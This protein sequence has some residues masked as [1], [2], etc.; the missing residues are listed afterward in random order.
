M[1]SPID[2]LRFVHTAIQ[3][4]SAALVSLAADA[5]ALPAMQGRL[6]DLADLIRAHTAGEEAGLFPALAER[7][8]HYA[9]TYLHDHVDER[10]TLDEAA[11]ALAAAVAGEAG[12]Q[13][14]LQAALL[15][16]QLHAHAHIAKEN[17]LVLPLVAAEYSVPE[18]VAMVQK[19]LSTIP[20]QEMPRFVPWI[21][22]RNPLPAACAYV[23]IL[24]GAMPPPVFEMAKGW[25]RNGVDAERWQGLT[26]E[27]EG[28][29]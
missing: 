23:R 24:Q 29:A 27:I 14:R 28:L 9:D 8:P 15:R 17:E 16:L 21:V 25:I 3:V 6:T 1:P 4:E 26:A 7:Y 20:P 18:Q 11:A 19:V 2:S 22:A 12:A 5:A 10:Q 13:G